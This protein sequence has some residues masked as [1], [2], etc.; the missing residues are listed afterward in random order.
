MIVQVPF[1]RVVEFRRQLVDGVE[2]QRAAGGQLELAVEKRLA[3]GRAMRRLAVG[4]S[5]SAAYASSGQLT[6]MNAPG[7]PR[8]GVKRV[9]HRL[10]AGSRRADEQQRLRSR[11]L[12]RD[13]VPQRADRGAVAEQRT[14][15]TAARVAQELLGDAQLALERGGPFG[16]A[17]LERR[18]GRLQRL[19]G[20]AALLVELRVV[21]RAGDLVGDDRDEP[22]IV[23]AEAS[24]ARALDREDADQL[25]ADQ[26]R[27]RDLALGVGSPGTGT[28]SPSSAPRP[29]LTICRRCAA[30]Y[31]ALLAQVADV[32]HLALLRD[33]ADD[34]GADPHAAADR[35]VLVAAA[36]D[37]AQRLAAR[38]DQQDDRVMEL[39]QLVHRPQRDVVDLLEV[40][41]RVDGGRDAL[42]D[43][44]LRGLPL[45]C[46]VRDRPVR[47]AARPSDQ[48]L[49]PRGAYGNCSTE[50]TR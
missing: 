33:H 48:A 41:R 38:L 14:L 26:Q 19:G 27:D 16:D 50:R 37:H 11:G 34:A 4:D 2:E 25:V 35:L 42:Q 31:G 43:L 20:A 28:A 7:A 1:E 39:E 3:A 21:D 40:E 13:G 32:Q 30:A 36:G 17:R 49:E 44:E 46:S 5:A 9:R 45:D 23:L 10:L 47:L 15:D 12:A 18:V 29:A 6:K 24:A 22:A 8:R